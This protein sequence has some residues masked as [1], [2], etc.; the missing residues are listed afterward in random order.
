MEELRIY[1]VQSK[2]IDNKKYSDPIS[3]LTD[4]SGI[5]IITYFESQVDLVS[6]VIEEL[7]EIDGENSLNRDQLL[8]DD[9]IGYRSVHFVC[10]LGTEREE[11]AEYQLYSGL[12]FEIQVRTVLQHAWAEL[13]HDRSYKFSGELPPKLQRQLNLYSGMLEVV[14]GGFDSIAKE[15]DEYQDI[16][17]S[18]D[19]STF[20][21]DEIDSI[22][23]NKFVVESAESNGL[24]P[25]VDTGIDQDIVREIKSYGL[26]K[27]LDIFELITED[28]IKV[29]KKYNVDDT[30]VGFL[31]SLLLYNDIEKY[32]ANSYEH[33]GWGMIG[34]VDV[35]FLS[36]KFERNK[37]TQLLE[38]HG[39]K[40]DYDS[41]SIDEL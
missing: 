22:N 27:I 34:N 12:K 5:R 39:I 4:I 3:Q 17:D 38:D 33:G 18:G 6:R 19:L 25:F 1:P 21:E 20:M 23:L 36:S 13:A 11:L 35:D 31:R 15:L 9:R 32:F 7:F 29:Y 10:S 8:G 41:I 28:F 16:V 37:V 2:K 40:I 14:D 26:S 24:G 30:N